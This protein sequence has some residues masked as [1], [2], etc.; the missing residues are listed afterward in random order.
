[1]EVDLLR[2]FGC[3]VVTHEEN[4]ERIDEIGVLRTALRAV[5]SLESYRTVRKI[6][7]ERRCDILHVQNFF[8]LLS[9]SVYYAAHAEGVPVVQTLHNY[10]LMCPVG[11]FNRDGQVC[12]ECR[13]KAF[14]W[15]GIAHRCYRGSATATSAVS[16]MI[17]VNRALG[18]WHDKVDAYIVLTDFM[19]EKFI[20]GGFPAEKLYVKPNFLDPDPQP[21]PGGGNFALYAG[22]LAPEKG[23][24]TM[25]KAWEQVGDRMPLKIAGAGPL[26]PAVREA[27]ARIPSIEFIGWQSSAEVLRLMG[28]AAL[29]IMPTVFYEGHPR[30]V[31][32]AFARQ[33]PVVASRVGAMLEM[34]EDGKSG[35][36]F[37]PGDPADLASKV[38]WAIGHRERVADIGREAR[39]QFEAKY[40]ASRNFTMLMEIYQ[41]VGA[42]RFVH[43]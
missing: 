35:I 43:A 21:G 15:P 23:I 40:V 38:S 12:E 36:L 29:F 37:N 3:E 31:V 41:A 34:V 22:R 33:A 17:S 11:T 7:R 25:L 5:W 30:S 24:G 4:N 42:R 39:N 32:E 16:A 18:T 10:R 1:M 14:P 2:H 20:Q 28:E 9:P 26:E 19:R 8:P 27:A 6:L 13:N